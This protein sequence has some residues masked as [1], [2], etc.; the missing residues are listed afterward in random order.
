MKKFLFIALFLFATFFSTQK[1][2][3]FPAWSETPFT[4]NG[5]TYNHYMVFHTLA[6]D[7]NWSYAYYGQEDVK[8]VQSTNGLDMECLTG[9]CH[10]L[11]RKSTDGVN[12]ETTTEYYSAG[13]PSGLAFLSTPYDLTTL[14]DLYV[15]QDIVNTSGTVVYS[16]TPPEECSSW[17]YSDWSECDMNGQQ[18]RTILTSSPENCEGGS[19]VISQTCGASEVF[20]NATYS[21]SVLYPQ[22]DNNHFAD[23]QPN[24]NFKIKMH[25]VVP[26]NSYSDTDFEL[27]QCPTLN[28]DENCTLTHKGLISEIRAG[29]DNWF[30]AIANYNAFDNNTGSGSVYV[31]VPVVLDEYTALYSFLSQHSSGKTI[32]AT[33]IGLHGVNDTKLPFAEG[34]LLN[35]GQVQSDLGF[36]GNTFRD[37]FVPSP[38]Y[39]NSSFSEIQNQMENTAPFS[40]YYLLK[41]KFLNIGAGSTNTV[42][43]LD[44]K[45]GSKDMSLPFID[46]S[47]SRLTTFF[48]N[49]R[50]FLSYAFYIFFAIYLYER[51]LNIF[52]PIE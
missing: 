33:P 11:Y 35:N 7:R 34:A 28:F 30:T 43:D 32:L 10:M 16:P 47:D 26:E 48:S 8:L 50:T 42:L 44:I 45:Y 41:D 40:Y 49:L 4:Y 17:T 46:F 15:S 3:A 9:S 29:S 19:P 21:L 24:A 27:Y 25:Y 37:I 18:T 1:V 39:L 23:V 12:W 2:L 36:W 14:S 6:G 38:D 5:I 52:K 20:N 31:E 51:V 22:L 13:T